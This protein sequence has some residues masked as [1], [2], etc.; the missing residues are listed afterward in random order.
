[1]FSIGAP[2]VITMAFGLIQL[3][4][5]PVMRGRLVTVTVMIAFGTQP[6]ASFLIGV[7]AQV[8]TIPTAILINGALLLVGGATMLLFRPDLR[9][10][11][12]NQHSAAPN[13]A[14][15]LQ[16]AQAAIEVLESIEL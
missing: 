14:D 3:L 12:A 7:S 1:M 2:T 6:I 4:A 13:P 8:F 9:N 15:N 5:P 10:W 11:S 16:T